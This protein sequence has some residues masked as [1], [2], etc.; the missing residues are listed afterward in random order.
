MEYVWSLLLYVVCSLR[1][2]LVCRILLPSHSIPANVFSAAYLDNA[3]GRCIDGGGLGEV[4][5][6]VNPNSED[7][8]G[9]ESSRVVPTQW[10]P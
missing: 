9:A 6:I 8:H 2:H 3:N 4:V 5:Q 10:L 1:V 7:L